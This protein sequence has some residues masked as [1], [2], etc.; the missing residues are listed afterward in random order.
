MW[1]RVV[2]VC[3]CVCG[4]VLCV[5]VTWAD[6]VLGGGSDHDGETR[7]GWREVVRPWVQAVLLLLAGL[8][9]ATVAVVFVVFIICCVKAWVG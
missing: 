5:C 8:A 1:L 4:C 2:C 7:R 3:V 6:L 9:A